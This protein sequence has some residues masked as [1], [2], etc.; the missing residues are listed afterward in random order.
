MSDDSYQAWIE[1]RRAMRPPDDFPDRV[2]QLVMEVQTKQRHVFAL[3]LA[4][5]IERWR[6]ARYAAA[7]AA[8]L[9]GSVPFVTYFAYL[10]Q[11]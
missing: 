4:S 1:Q 11:V 2:M 10:L 5:W 8:L 3:R 9:V 7:S 6:L